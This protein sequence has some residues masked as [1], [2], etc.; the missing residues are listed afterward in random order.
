M[1]AIAG[2]L[3]LAGAF[4][5]LL[6]ILM[7]ISKGTG[8]SIG[9]R[10]NVGV[11]PNSLSETAISLRASVDKKFKEKNEIEEKLL[12]IANNCYI[13]YFHFSRNKNGLETA[14]KSGGFKEEAIKL[15]AE[16]YDKKIRE[17]LLI[18]LEAIKNYEQF[19][20]RK[21]NM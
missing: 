13:E 4:G 17:H 3:Y 7:L 16:N 12:K 9:Y 20:G 5:F 1:D 18:A 14:L 8:M 10:G 6:L 19:S 2:I 21:F 15:W 11:T